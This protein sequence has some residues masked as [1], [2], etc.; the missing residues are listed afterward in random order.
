VSLFDGKTLAGW[1]SVEGGEF[2]G[3]G[4]VAVVRG[5]I[6]LGRGANLTG[7]ACPAQHPRDDYEI[8]LEAMRVGEGDT[9]CLV[10]FP[11][12]DAQCTLAVGAYD[13]RVVGLNCVDGQGANRN[14]TTRRMGFEAGR[15]YRIRLRVT[16]AAIEASLD[17]QKIIE[18]PRAGHTFT[19]GSAYGP[20]P[21]L[22]VCGW[23]RSV[24]L[25]NIRLRRVEGP[26]AEPRG[27]EGGRG[28]EAGGRQRT[29]G[30]RQRTANGKRGGR[31][32]AGGRRQ[33][34]VR[35]A[36]RFRRGCFRG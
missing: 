13:G 36:G 9:L 6:A 22:G 8:S 24:A 25:R 2:H 35:F 30:G 20:I 34:A 12:G 1:Q 14:T 10:V 21:G 29:V 27:E 16:A 11:V 15:W 3:H 19:P 17:D 18:Q 28:Q 31:Q 26:D 5:V 4:E 23:R 32:S 33:A 7:V